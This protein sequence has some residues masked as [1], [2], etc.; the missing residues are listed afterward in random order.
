V[1][2][3]IVQPTPVRLEYL[4]MVLDSYR[5]AYQ[6]DMPVDAWS[7]HNFILN[8]ASCDYYRD[9]VPAGQL[10]QVCWGADIPPGV[11]ATDGLRIT[12]QENDSVKLFKEQVERFR[13][14]M[15][16]NGYRNTP[17]FL[18]EFGV[19][20]PEAK[21]PEFN[22][23]RVNDFMNATFDYLMT[24]TNPNTGYPGDDNRLV[25]R[26]AW[27][28]TDD[29]VDFNG[30]LFNRNA[31]VATSRTAMGDN[32][33]AYA[34]SVGAELDYYLDKVSVVGA[35]VAGQNGMTVTLEA[36]IGNSGNLASNAAAIVRFYN[37]DPFNGGVQIVAEQ[38]IS[39][40]GCGEKGAVR[41][42]WGGVQPGTYTIYA[43]VQVLS[44]DVD[45]SNNQLS[46][47]VTVAP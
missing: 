2:G 42:E 6:T 25:Q 41:V 44:S 30:F 28:S 34:G 32:F 19:L 20:M 17:A 22:T 35:P 10:G 33:V 24:A 9:K 14:W 23:V 7:F 37:G 47:P 3:T 46:V 45:G 38:T 16:D 5:N 43:R 31:P 11:N 27:Y 40:A 8:E 39:V 4:D 12:I 18:S 1:A 26:F 21:F 15:A 36:V 13:E 29:N